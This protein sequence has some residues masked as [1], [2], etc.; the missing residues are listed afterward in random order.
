MA[1]FSTGFEGQTLYARNAARQ[2]CSATGGAANQAE[3][4]IYCRCH[5]TLRGQ[6]FPEKTEP[7]GQR[8][9]WSTDA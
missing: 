9:A 2:G 8:G 1:G 7:P 6:P 4:S 5:G 3:V